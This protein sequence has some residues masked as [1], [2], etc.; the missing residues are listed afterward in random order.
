MIAPKARREERQAYAVS[1]F[2]VIGISPDWIALCEVTAIAQ[3]N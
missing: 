3:P 1:L 2:F